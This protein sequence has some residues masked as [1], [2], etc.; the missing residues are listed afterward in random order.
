MR[1]TAAGSIHPSTASQLRGTGT[2]ETIIWCTPTAWLLT[3]SGPTAGVVT[4]MNLVFD[5][6]DRP[7]N[8]PQAVCQGTIA[9]FSGAIE[10]A[11]LEGFVVLVAEERVFEALSSTELPYERS[12]AGS[13]GANVACE[14]R[15]IGHFLLVLG[16]ANHFTAHWSLIKNLREL[17]SRLS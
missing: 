10:G 1:T 3:T 8:W 6:P 16:Q 7:L 17:F 4:P 9:H 11:C 5:R 12:V 14:T 2:Y 13:L 15:F